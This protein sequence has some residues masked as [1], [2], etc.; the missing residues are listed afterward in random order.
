MLVWCWP[1][2]ELGS[3]DVVGFSSSLWLFPDSVPFCYIHR[4]R[5]ITIPCC[6]FLLLINTLA[7]P[8]G[9]HAGP[10]LE[11][12]SLHAYVPS[13]GLELASAPLTLVKHQTCRKVACHCPQSYI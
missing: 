7:N 1:G 10:Q 9:S 12:N 6:K 13:P 4:L 5:P 8:V 11:N 3:S 2:L